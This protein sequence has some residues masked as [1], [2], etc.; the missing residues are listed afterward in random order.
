[1][2]IEFAS[3]QYSLSLGSE[4]EEEGSGV[5]G[6]RATTG[7]RD[8]RSGNSVRTRPATVP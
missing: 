8:F 4:G 3:V 1:V 7:T 5:R 2:E 6:S